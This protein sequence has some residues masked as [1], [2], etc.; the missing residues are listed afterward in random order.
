[1][2]TEYQDYFQKSHQLLR[3]SIRSFVDQEIKPHIDAWER[4]GEFPKELYQKAG[5]IGFLGIGFPEE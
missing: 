5:D 4:A 3:A 1:M 2:Q